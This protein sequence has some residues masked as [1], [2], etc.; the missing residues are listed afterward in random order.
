M[1]LKA[2][3]QHCV[4]TTV[5]SKLTQTRLSR[6]RSTYQLLLPFEA[7]QHQHERRRGALRA[8]G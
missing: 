2:G 5:L 3:N 4:H 7:T 6:L 1:L 8:V